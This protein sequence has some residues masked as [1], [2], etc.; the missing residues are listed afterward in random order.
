MGQGSFSKETD[1]KRVA[2]ARRDLVHIALAA[3]RSADESDVL[4]EI[5]RTLRK[6]GLRQPPV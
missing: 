4:H 3:T 5:T 1:G 2:R 6:S